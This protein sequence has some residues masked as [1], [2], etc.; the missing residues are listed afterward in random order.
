[1]NGFAVWFLLF[2]DRSADPMIVLPAPLIFEPRNR[3]HLP[4]PQSARYHQIARDTSTLR[5]RSAIPR[6][7]RAALPGRYL[8]SVYSAPSSVLPLVAPHSLLPQA[9]SHRHT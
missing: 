2:S 8:L 4:A 1:M 9:N 6:F 5:R 7:H 3:L